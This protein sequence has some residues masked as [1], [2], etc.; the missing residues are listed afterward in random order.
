[1]MINCHWH[2]HCC[3][4]HHCRPQQWSISSLSLDHSSVNMQKPVD[5]AAIQQ[6]ILAWQ[7]AINALL[8]SLLLAPLSSST[9]KPVPLPPFLA[10]FSV[11]TWQPVDLNAINQEILAW[12]PTLHAMLASSTPPSPMTVTTES[13]PL[14]SDPSL[15]DICKPATLA[16]LQC[17][18]L[19]SQMP[20]QP[21]AP[22]QPFDLDAINRMLHDS[23]PIISWLLARSMVLPSTPVKT[24]LDTHFKTPPMSPLMEAWQPSD[25]EAIKLHQMNGLPQQLIAVQNTT[26]SSMT[27][28]T[29]TTNDMHFPTMLNGVNVSCQMQPHS[30]IMQ[31]RP[32]HVHSSLVHQSSFPQP[33][34]INL[35]IATLDNLL[36]Q[37]TQ[38][39]TIITQTIPAITNLSQETL[40]LWLPPNIH[41]HTACCQH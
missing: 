6:D 4:H 17:K 14:S 24:L 11:N 27:A 3:H 1:M 38:L 31:R 2:H 16:V 26:T 35:L 5:L 15:A 39:A 23:Q 10:D 13:S 19:I 28:M 34:A 36:K 37:T 30:Q 29:I 7:L 12:Q 25:F 21:S 8:A 9:A 20:Q 18:H 22:W 41:K 40:A 32:Y 33:P